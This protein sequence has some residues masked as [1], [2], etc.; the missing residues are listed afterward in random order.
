MMDLVYAE[1]SVRTKA[2]L[3][4][5]AHGPHGYAKALTRACAQLFSEPAG[6]VCRLKLHWAGSISI[7]HQKMKMRLPRN[8]LKG[9]LGDPMPAV[10]CGVGHNIPLMFK[11]LHVCAVAP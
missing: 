10:L 6:Q 9:A 4:D 3:R 5:A 2:K 8:P 11:M 7:G 1:V